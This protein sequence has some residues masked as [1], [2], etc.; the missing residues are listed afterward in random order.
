MTHAQVLLL[1]RRAFDG[2]LDLGFNAS[3]VLTLLMHIADVLALSP[4]AIYTPADGSAAHELAAKYM[5]GATAAAAGLTPPQVVPLAPIS[6]RLKAAAPDAPA[7]ALDLDAELS[8]LDG[9]ADVQRKVKRAFCEPANVAFCPP[10][11]LTR[12]AILPYSE[13]RALLLKRK[14]D[15]GG[16]EAFT[17]AAAL[18][19]RYAAGGVHPGDLK[20]SV[21][22]GVEALLARVRASV[23]ADA[24]LAAALKE[25]DKVAKRSAKGGGGKAKK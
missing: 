6:L 19:A 10:L 5:A 4:K 12:H 2:A 11:A 13:G 25:V 17:D 7:D 9:T 3:H 8:L 16:D 24:A 1:A 22:D 18:E 21:R 14:P 15:D 23:A 20:P